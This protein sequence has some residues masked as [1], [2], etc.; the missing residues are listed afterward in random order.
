MSTGIR[1]IA[2]HYDVKTGALLEEIEI[3]DD[4]MRKAGILKDLGYL[5]M[6]Q[7]D[8]MTKCQDFRVSKQIKLTND[9][10][11]CPISG[12][13]TQKH[14]IYSS[15]FHSIFSD[16]TV[17]IQRLKCKGGCNLPYKLEGIFGTSTHPDLLKKQ[18]ALTVEKSYVRAS[19]ELNY[20]AK[21]DRAINNRTNLSRVSNMVS[22]VMEDIQ[23][24]EREV[25][26]YRTKEIISTIDGG[27]IKKRGEGR[28]FEAIIAKVHR[29]EN[30]I[31]VDKN[32]HKI[33][34]KRIVASS[35]DDNQKKIKKQFLNACIDQGMGKETDLIC[36]ADGADN[37]WSVT[38]LAKE[39]S[40][41]VLEILDWFHIAKKFKNTE[42]AVTSAK[43][44]DLDSAKWHLWYGDAKKAISNLEVLIKDS[45]EI[46]PY[47]KLKS[48]K[49][50]I[51]NNQEKIVD[52]DER[53]SQG[54]AY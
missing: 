9:T 34:D 21:K 41:S 10:K 40:R 6:E 11:E 39:Q 28:S 52:Y 19:K 18:A 8:I 45:E 36:L 1:I 17:E 48:L 31:K 53:D 35:R 47:N 26:D 24:N 38:E 13:K 49:Q 30:V 32:N 50:Y 16:H 42:S 2:Q 14:W 23:T 12:A 25:A 29:A 22:K 54:L 37:C 3:R 15:E 43:T 20:D 44:T 7:I 4:E 51:E 33:I 5:H 46:K 27:H